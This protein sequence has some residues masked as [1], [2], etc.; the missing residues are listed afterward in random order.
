MRARLVVAVDDAGV[1]ALFAAALAAYTV[2][3]ASRGDDALA[4]V[5]RE[6]PDLVVLDVQLPGLD[7]VAVARALASGPA[8]AAIPVV[9]CSCAG[10]EAAAARLRA[11]TVAFVPKPF[12]MRDL[13]GAIELALGG[14]LSPPPPPPPPEFPAAGMAWP[15][16]AALV[17]L[18]QAGVTD[19]QL[20]RLADL[21]A[22]VRRGGGAAGAD[23]A[24]AGRRAF[25]RWLVQT[26][27]VQEDLP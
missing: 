25:A 5:R 22:R 27:R 11:G 12:A 8:T 24:A 19:A 10:P 1:R 17:G 7:G 16:A 18:L 9:L 21:R 4:L 26:G 23:R 2:I 15:A 3:P 13:Q 20:S 14:G 6:R